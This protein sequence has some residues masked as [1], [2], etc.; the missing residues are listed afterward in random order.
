VALL[1]TQYQ[2]LTLWTYTMAADGSSPSFDMSGFS[3]IYF[4]CSWTGADGTDAQ[5][6]PQSA[7]EDIDSH[8]VNIPASSQI[9]TVNASS[10]TQAYSYPFPTPHF[11]RLHF[12]ANSNTA[13]TLT[14]K[15]RASRQIS[16]G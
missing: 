7:H 3:G 4:E 6:I 1:Q 8:Y 5:L 12:V 10:G 16:Y 15:I 13:G 9:L 11:V 2:D 14:V